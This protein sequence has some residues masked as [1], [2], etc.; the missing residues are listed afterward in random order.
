MNLRVNSPYTM[1]GAHLTTEVEKYAIDFFRCELEDKILNNTA[2]YLEMEIE[3]SE[4]VAA[5]I[6]TDPDIEI[7]T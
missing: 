3:C 5:Q 7:I 4:E 6:A 2:P 1:N